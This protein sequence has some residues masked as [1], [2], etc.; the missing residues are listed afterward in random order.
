[1]PDANGK[2][3]GIAVPAVPWCRRCKLVKCTCRDRCGG[4][5]QFLPRTSFYSNR[6]GD[7]WSYEDE[8]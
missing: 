7:C 2:L 8:F 5:G 6:C 1:M 4:C 3:K